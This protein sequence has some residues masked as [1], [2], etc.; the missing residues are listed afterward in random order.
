M[1]TLERPVRSG[2]LIAMKLLHKQKAIERQRAKSRNK[3]PTGGR[4]GTYLTRSSEERGSVTYATKQCRWR[5]GLRRS[6]EL[7]V[8]TRGDSCDPDWIRVGRG[9]PSFAE[10]G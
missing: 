10:H 6:S 7:P 8:A 3:L 2:P 1:K 5:W 4:K 9:A